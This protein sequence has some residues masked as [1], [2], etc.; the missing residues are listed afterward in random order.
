MNNPWMMVK[1][2]LAEHLES[3]V[4]SGAPIM[5]R[6]FRVDETGEL[7]YLPPHEEEDAWVH[8]E[9][10][11]LFDC[12][13]I[14]SAFSVDLVGYLTAIQSYVN[15]E[16]QFVIYEFVLDCDDLTRIERAFLME[17]AS[18]A[19]G[20]E[21]SRIAITFV[22]NETDPDAPIIAPQQMIRQFR[23]MGRFPDTKI[24]LDKL[25]TQEVK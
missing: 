22:S 21:P 12:L 3:P 9:Y 24:G 23:R 17:L 7:M 8:T 11:R 20:V 14:L 6:V 5:F 10:Q 4:S 16:R 19:L 15:E 13:A 18:Q 1:Q 25:T 2:Q